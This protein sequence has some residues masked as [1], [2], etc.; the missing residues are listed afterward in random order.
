MDGTLSKLDFKNCSYF[1]RYC[2]NLLTW[3][4]KS[5]SLLV[6]NT[7]RKEHNLF[8]KLFYYLMIQLSNNVYPKQQPKHN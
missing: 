5:P 2:N 7:F 1:L 8:K 4:T 3:N 6:K